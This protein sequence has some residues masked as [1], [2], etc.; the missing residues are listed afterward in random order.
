MF[1]LLVALVTVLTL[2]SAASQTAAQE[3]ELCPA[4]DA[5]LVAT[6]SAAMIAALEASPPASPPAE[7]YGSPTATVAVSPTGSPTTAETCR[8]DIGVFVYMPSVIKIPVGTSVIWTNR[9][10]QIHTATADDSSWDT[11]DLSPTDTS[12]PIVFDTP[13]PIPYHCDKHPEFMFGM[14][15]VE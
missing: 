15:E 10:N 8:V 9:H 7:P 14:I 3:V 5:S 11:H 12:A 1:R 6:P 13:G 2:V 4:G